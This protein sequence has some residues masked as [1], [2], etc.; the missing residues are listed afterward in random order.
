M[1]WGQGQEQREKSGFR[2]RRNRVVQRVMEC[3]QGV[4]G[5]RQKVSDRRVGEGHR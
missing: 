5:I 2:C 3:K 4:T 1:C